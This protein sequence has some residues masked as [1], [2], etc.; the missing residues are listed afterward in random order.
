MCYLF[1][2]SKYFKVILRLIFLF[3]QQFSILLQK[4]T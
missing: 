4:D 3:K 2:N 1:K